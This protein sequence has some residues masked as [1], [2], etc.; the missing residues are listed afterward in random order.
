MVDEQ[1]GP[2]V[3]Q[4][5]EWLDEIALNQM[6]NN[7]ERKKQKKNTETHVHCKYM[8]LLFI[9]YSIKRIKFVWTFDLDKHYVITTVLDWFGSPRKYGNL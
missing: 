9:L 2:I 4:Y 8:L 3:L 6:S 7:E 5:D 1:K